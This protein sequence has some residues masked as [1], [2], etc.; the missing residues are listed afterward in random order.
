MAFIYIESCG[1]VNE[2]ERT[3]D[4]SDILVVLELPR[5]EKKAEPSSSSEKKKGLIPFPQVPSYLVLVT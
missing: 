3:I 2:V 1:Y 4:G 5:E